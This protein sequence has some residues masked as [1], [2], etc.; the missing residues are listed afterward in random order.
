VKPAGPDLP[1][2]AEWQRR[3]EVADRYMVPWLS[4]LR[5]LTGTTILEYGCGTGPVCASLAPHVAR[6]IGYDI[7]ERAIS[8]GASR[9]EADGNPLNVEL[10][11]ASEDRILDAVADHSGEPDIVL[12]YAVLEHLTVRERL[13]VLELAFE[14]VRH[15]GLVVVVES[16]N[17]LAAVDWH[18]SFLPFLCQLPEPLA[19]EYAKRSPREEFREAMRVAAAE[20]GG[21]A[22]TELTRWGRGVSFHEFELV[23]G[24]LQNHVVGG[25]TTPNWPR[26]GRYIPRSSSW[27][28]RSSACDPTCR[29]CSGAIG[30]TSPSRVSRS[31][32]RRRA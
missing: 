12:L 23:L 20:N 14:I 31:T 17:R 15:D 5:P 32:R 7:D 16:P 21:A 6:Y 22:Q 1:D 26:S 27:R 3:R 8:E 28:E 24:E 10:S 13:D 9:L 19:V 29:P 4:R 18:T 11:W 2:L 30:S 25:A